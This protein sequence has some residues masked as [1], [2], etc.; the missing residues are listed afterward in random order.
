MTDASTSG[1]VSTG[2]PGVVERARKDS[3]YQFYSLAHLID[4]QCLMRAYSRLREDAA[5]GVDGVTVEVYGRTLQAN[6]KGLYERLK[7]MQYRHQPILR[8]H[9]PKAKG[10][11]RPLGISTVE[12]KIVQGALKGTHHINV[13]ST[14]RYTES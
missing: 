7:S 4:E 6:L 9:V 12:D 14:K 13:D 11:T 8:V 10:G 3:N 2:L 1:K 5:V